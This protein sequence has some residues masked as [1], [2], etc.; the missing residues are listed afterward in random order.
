MTTSALKL[1]SHLSGLVSLCL[2]NLPF[3]LKVP[4]LQN[5]LLLQDRKADEVSILCM[6]IYTSI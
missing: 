2:P 3:S 4:Y 5:C 1:G 6:E